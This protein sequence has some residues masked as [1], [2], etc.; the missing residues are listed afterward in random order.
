M[1]VLLLLV[2][3]FFFGHRYNDDYP[4]RMY[5]VIRPVH[6]R[7]LIFNVNFMNT[8]MCVCSN[9]KFVSHLNSA[10]KSLKYKRKRRQRQRRRHSLP[11]CCCCC[12]RCST[13]IDINDNCND[14][15]DDESM[16][17]KIKLSHQKQKNI[18]HQTTPTKDVKQVNILNKFSNKKKHCDS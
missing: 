5:C 13:S 17:V 3:L 11:C 9:E 18:T 8:C 2:F 14:D 16:I 1:V 4:V 12:C 15:D 10:P 6:S 7:L